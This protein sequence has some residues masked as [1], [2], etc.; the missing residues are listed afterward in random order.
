M[1][2]SSDSRIAGCEIGMAEN[3]WWAAALAAIPTGI[4]SYLVA[5][6]TKVY[7]ARGAAEAALIGAGPTIIA[8]QNRR[9]EAIQN[10]N[11]RLWKQIQEGYT[12]ERQC[13]ENMGKLQ[14]QIT[15]QRHQIRDLQAK[16]VALEFKLS[17]LTGN[18]NRSKED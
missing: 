7:D 13:Q 10:D 16:V 5:R 14:M 17:R 15:D 2:P 6:S 3:N 4:I 12:R 1:E 9:I 18:E 11:G 8:E